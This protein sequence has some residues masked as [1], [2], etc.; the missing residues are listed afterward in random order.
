MKITVFYSLVTDKDKKEKVLKDALRRRDWK[1]GPAYY[2]ALYES[3]DGHLIGELSEIIIRSTPLTANSAR[4]ISSLM[5]RTEGL[6]YFGSNACGMSDELMRIMA[7]NMKGCNVQVSSGIFNCLRVCVAEDLQ[8]RL[9][10]ITHRQ[11]S[12]HI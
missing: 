1:D 7:D 2:A 6:K 8:W 9:R 5:S 3:N 4:V 10:S 12:R 11:V